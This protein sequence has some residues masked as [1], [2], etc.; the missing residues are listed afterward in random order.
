MSL[1]TLIIWNYSNLILNGW[2]DGCSVSLKDRTIKE[3]T[4][5]F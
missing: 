1:D 5:S 3:I 4:Y 2:M